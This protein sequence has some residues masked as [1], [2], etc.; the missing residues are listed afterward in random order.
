MY[1]LQLIRRISNEFVLCNEFK[2]NNTNNV[3]LLDGNIGQIMTKRSCD[4]QYYVLDSTV[5]TN[6]SEF[7]IGQINLNGLHS[8][9]ILQN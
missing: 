3:V 7:I 9:K 8:F 4:R 2:G 6:N 5:T 1:L